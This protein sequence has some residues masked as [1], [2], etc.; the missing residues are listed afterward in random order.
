MTLLAQTPVPRAL[1]ALGVP[2]MLAMVITAV[3]NLVDTYFVSSLGTEALGAVTVVF[4]LGQLVTGLGLLFGNGAAAYLPRLLGRGDTATA[5]KVASTALWGS[6]GIGVVVIGGLLGFIQPILRQLGAVES[7]LPDATTYAVIYLAGSVFAVIN[8]AMNNLFAAQGATATAMV[9]LMVG[10]VLNVILDP[11]LIFAAHWGVA[12][13]AI[14]TCISQLATTALYVRH[15][16]VGRSVF[17]FRTREVS[18]AWAIWSEILKVGLPTLLFQVLTSVAISVTNAAAVSYGPS[19]LAAMGPVTKVMTVG[20]LIVFGFLKGFQPLAGFSFGAGRID[21]LR[22]AIWASLIASTGFCVV[23][24]ATVALAAT[25]IMAAF[26]D[27]DDMMIAIG[28]TAL[29]ASGISFSLFGFYTVYSFLLLTMGKALSG[30]VL[31]A[32]RQGICFLPVIWIL[33]S[34]LGLDGVLYAQPV[35]DVL[36]AMMAAVMAWRL[37]RSLRETASGYT[38]STSEKDPVHES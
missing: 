12:G 36:A 18:A 21:R 23:F 31:G 37:H 15:V 27:S 26:T 8:V 2:T 35:A 25:P 6:I 38:G 10:A 9:A 16:V 4:P 20:S 14:A 28:T 22:A 11:I 19:A 17:T 32:A 30:C 7:I 24:G 34:L 29:R 1:I 33:P 3:Y 13:A 5:N